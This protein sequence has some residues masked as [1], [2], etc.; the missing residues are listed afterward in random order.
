MHRTIIRG[1]SDSREKAEV[2]QAHLRD[3]RHCFHAIWESGS[4]FIC[5]ARAVDATAA[6]YSSSASVGAKSLQAKSGSSFHSHIAQSLLSQRCWPKPLQ[7]ERRMPE[8]R[9]VR[10][11]RKMRRSLRPHFNRPQRWYPPRRLLAQLRVLCPPLRPSAKSTL[12]QMRLSA[13]FWVG[14]SLTA[15]GEARSTVS[16]R[17]GQSGAPASSLAVEAPLQNL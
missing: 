8:C 12:E 10:R 14:P 9:R 4:G 1:G 5:Q 16:G 6:T 11:R 3:S 17:R 7:L 2:K 15:R 13:R